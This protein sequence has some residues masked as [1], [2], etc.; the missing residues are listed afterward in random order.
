LNKP[1]GKTTVLL[2]GNEKFFGDTIYIMPNDSFENIL[3]K[4]ACVSLGYIKIFNEAKPVLTISEETTAK[5][6]V[7]VKFSRNSKK[8]WIG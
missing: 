3:S 8:R 7:G 4:N 2:E 5:E 1:L 6:R